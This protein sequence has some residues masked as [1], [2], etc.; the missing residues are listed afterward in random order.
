MSVKVRFRK[1]AKGHSLYLDIYQRGMRT[2]ENSGLVVSHDYS[3]PMQDQ[4]GKII[5]DANGKPKYYKPT[6][7]DK[8]KLEIMEKRRLH[9]ELQLKNTEYEFVDAN[10]RNENLLDYITRMG[11]RRNLYAQVEKCFGKRLPINTI[12]TSTVRRFILHLKRS[13]IAENTQCVYYNSLVAILNCAKRD[14]LLTSNPCESIGRNEKPKPQ[15]SKRDYLLLEEVGQLQACE[16]AP[17]SCQVKEAFLFACMTGLRI[18]DLLAL[19]YSDIKDGKL[20][21][22]MQK[23]KENFHYLPL[24]TQALRL[25]EKLEK[26]PRGEKVFWELNTICTAT[27]LDILKEWVERAGIKKHVTWHVA[28]HTCATLLLTSGVNIYTVSKI[29]GHSSVKITERYGKIIDQKKEEAVN[30]I[31]DF[32]G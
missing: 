15:E 1:S 24:S 22:R 21:Y 7:D 2:C 26:D 14:H 30:S 32:G 25:I 3:K 13:G 28:R 8:L 20:Q 23:V 12:N 19:R 9:R 16:P 6:G 11:K 31:P 27:S 5:T 17:Y 10:A 29:L 18:S 4:L